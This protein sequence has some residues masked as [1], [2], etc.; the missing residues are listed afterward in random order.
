MWRQLTS[1]MLVESAIISGGVE[2]SVV[3][4]YF[5]MGKVGK[6]QIFKGSRH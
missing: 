3:Y 1:K 4:K 5:T 6:A 2:S